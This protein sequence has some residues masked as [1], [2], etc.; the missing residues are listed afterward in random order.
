MKIVNCNGCGSKEL[1]E[2][3]GYVV[4]VYCQSRYV[5]NREDTPGK[6]TVI[7][8]GSDVQELLMK[9]RTDPANAR[10][11]AKLVLDLDPTNAQARAYLYP[12]KKKK[13]WF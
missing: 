11:Y 7:G 1:V 5:P 12:V 4:C 9:C 8:V 2:E 3:A 13:K 10:R 6:A